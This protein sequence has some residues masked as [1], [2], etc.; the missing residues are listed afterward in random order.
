MGVIL[1]K[2]KAMLHTDNLLWLLGRFW[3]GLRGLEM[4]GPHK[5]PP[6]G[7]AVYRARQRCDTPG[8]LT[9]G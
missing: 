5:P 8:H 1:H 9:P 3:Q 4:R 2:A 6:F 7:P